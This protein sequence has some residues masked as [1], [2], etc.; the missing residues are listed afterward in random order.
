MHKHES[1]G[2]A[3]FKVPCGREG[4]LLTF[5]LAMCVRG[6][7]ILIPLLV[8]P[9]SFPLFIPPHCWPLRWTVHP[10]PSKCSPLH[11]PPLSC[12]LSYWSLIPG[13]S[14]TLIPNF[15]QLLVF[16]YDSEVSSQ[17]M[18]VNTKLE[19][20]VNFLAAVP[21]GDGEILHAATEDPACHS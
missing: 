16:L 6:A 17:T 7:S 2:S 9:L 8:Q 1:P 3:D 21:W 18:I 4:S 13:I 15:I 14:N 19:M 11:L 5:Q 12:R 10:G 20:S